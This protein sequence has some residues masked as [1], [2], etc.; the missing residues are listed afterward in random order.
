MY[1]IYRKIE[2]YMRGHHNKTTCKWDWVKYGFIQLRIELLLQSKKI[3]DTYVL[4]ALCAI[5][6]TIIC[7]RSDAL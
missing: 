5:I 2:L 6:F 1:E 4:R 7:E 3:Y